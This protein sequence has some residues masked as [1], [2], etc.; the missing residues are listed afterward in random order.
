MPPVEKKPSA[1]LPPLI[2]AQDVEAEIQRL[3]LSQAGS[4]LVIR[5]YGEEGGTAENIEAFREML[6]SLRLY[7]Y[8]TGAGE[9]YVDAPNSSVLTR[10]LNVLA[11]E[12]HQ[13]RILD[14]VLTTFG[15]H[16][17]DPLAAILDTTPEG[18][19]MSRL[20][21]LRDM[22][23]AQI[24][25][26]KLTHESQDMLT[27][28]LLMAFDDAYLRMVAEHEERVQRPR[29]RKL[30][31]EILRLVGSTFHAALRAWPEHADNIA[32]LISRRMKGQV[33]L[34][35]VPTLIRGQICA[36]IEDFLWL[37]TAS[38]IES[39]LEPLFAQHSGL[40]SGPMPTLDRSLYGEFAQACWEIIADYS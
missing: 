14:R 11:R 32:M 4:G 40:M 20:G 12:Q 26:L 25:G 29:V 39:A 15:H 21:V 16:L 22:F 7:D 10:A 23:L 5:V 37:E 1:A 36:A 17:I 2:T 38:K 30:A 8:G 18:T 24:A 27:Q 19:I 31:Q 34:R 9:V 28:D 35:E 13:K 6:N 3:F 33:H